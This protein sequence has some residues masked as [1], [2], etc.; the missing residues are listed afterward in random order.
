MRQSSLGVIQRVEARY[1]LAVEVGHSELGLVGV[2][3][4]K[5]L[6]GSY[7]VASLGRLRLGK[8]RLGSR[9]KIRLAQVGQVPFRYGSLDK[10]LRG[11][12]RWVLVL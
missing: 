2:C 4:V 3:C 1:R 12:V 5:L 9:G 11:G 6:Q 7:G 10:A 8:F